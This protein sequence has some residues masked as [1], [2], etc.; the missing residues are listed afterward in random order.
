[1]G[2]SCDSRVRR[3]GGLRRALGAAVLATVAGLALLST[4]SLA[5]AHAPAEVGGDD[6]YILH[7]LDGQV[8]SAPPTDIYGVADDTVV[9]PFDEYSAKVHTVVRQKRPDNSYVP[10]TTL[11]FMD[12]VLFDEDWAYS[13]ANDLGDFRSGP[14]PSADGQWEVRAEQSSTDSDPDLFEVHTFTIDSTAPNTSIASGPPAFTNGSADPTFTFSGTDPDPPDGLASGIDYFECRVDGGPWNVCSSGN[15]VSVSAEGQR[16][17]E[18]RAVDKAGN[19]DQTPASYTWAIDETPPTIT[20]TTPKAGPPHDHFELHHGT[21][22]YTCTD[23][24][25]GSPPVSSGVDDCDDSGFDDD[26]PLGPKLI[27]FTATDKVGNAST[28]V[29]RAYVIDPPNYGDFVRA[30]NPRA[31]FRFEEPYP[32]GSSPQEI[33]MQDSS[34]NGHHGTYKNDVALRRQPAI[35]CERRPHPPRNCDFFANDP[36][37]PGWAAFFGE[38]DG[39][40]YVNGIS[41]GPGAYT[42]EAWVKPRTAGPMMV[43][44]QGRAGQ[45]FI[46][47]NQRLAFEQ[48]QDTVSSPGPNIPVGEWTH[49]AATW[50]GNSTRLYVNGVQVAHST[51][52]NKPPSGTSTFYVGYGERAPWFHGEIDEAAL[53]DR[54]LGAHAFQDRNA[55]GRAI[56]EPSPAGHEGND[57]FNTGLPYADPTE[58]KNNGLYAPGKLPP[59]DFAGD[60]HDAD[61]DDDVASCSATVDG[62]PIA[63]GGAL[64]QDLGLHDF[65]VTVRDDAGNEYVH[66]HTYDVVPFSSL[67]GRDPLVAY[68][69]LGDGQ[70]EHM[71]DSSPHGRHG[72]Y[73]NETDQGPVG[74]A[75]DGDHARDFRGPNGYGYANGLPSPSYQ[76]TLEAWVEPDDLHRDQSIAGHGDG[77]ELYLEGG[78]FKFRHGPQNRVVSSSPPY[79]PNPNSTYTQVVATWDGVDL[80]IY[81]N[82]QLEGTTESSRRPSS[83]STFYVGFG[84]IKPWFDGRIDEVAYY[85]TA[86]TPSRVL[87]HFMADPAADR[88]AGGGGAG[89]GGSGGTGGGGSGDGGGGSSIPGAGTADDGAGGGTAE[90][91]REPLRIGDELTLARRT[92][93]VPL[94][95][96]DEPSEGTVSLDAGKNHLGE[97]TFELGAREDDFAEIRLSKKGRKLLAS[98]R[99]VVATVDSGSGAPREQRLKVARP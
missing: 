73:R 77:G 12:G 8:L 33:P 66:K 43:M 54:A 85:S 18:V 91:G 10:G 20:V 6:L 78:V 27:T 45:L 57:P 42:M 74:I 32:N 44:S 62:N 16:T 94:Y 89:T 30:D 72:E 40:G 15:Q 75:G 28:P 68:Y 71:K 17:F 84:E 34:G 24:P 13:T 65:V 51:S 79:A 1:V 80:R 97:A 50:D 70:H 35:S 88:D 23:P 82:G 36:D 7:P 39:Y 60:C 64:P 3:G 26:I 14:F 69:R 38:R 52:A 63:Q 99:F 56:N 48:S 58:P 87:Q 47:G 95:G 96:G 76:M 53:Y 37:R 98:R 49:V 22:D 29:T 59:A 2:V 41:R 4:G 90:D 93:M 19:A 92:A 81:V 86:L 25:S 83:S 5:Q 61:G 9:P 11:V 21:P 67:Y 46:D 55:I 31:Y